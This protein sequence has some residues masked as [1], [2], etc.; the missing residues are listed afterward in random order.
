MYVGG[1]GDLS[2]SEL[3]VLRILCPVGFPVVGKYL[4]VLLQ[5]ICHGV[6]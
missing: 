5:S 3:C 4:S 6:C 2:E 1:Y